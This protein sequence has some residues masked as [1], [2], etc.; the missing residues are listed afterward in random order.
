MNSRGSGGRDRDK[1]RQYYSGAAKRKAREEI[2]ARESEAKYHFFSQEIFLFIFGIYKFLLSKVSTM[3]SGVKGPRKLN[4]T[5]SRS[6]WFRISVLCELIQRK[7]V[8]NNEY[9]KKYS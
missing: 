8:N 3:P 7:M 5:L 2:A 4:S 6:Y 9:F 1:H